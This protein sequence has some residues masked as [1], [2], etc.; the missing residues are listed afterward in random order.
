MSGEEK[1][2]NLALRGMWPEAIILCDEI[3]SKISDPQSVD[4]DRYLLEIWEN[5]KTDAY[6]TILE[7]L[8]SN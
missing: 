5:K 3:I 7:N 1:Y 2:D 6:D 8:L 4:F